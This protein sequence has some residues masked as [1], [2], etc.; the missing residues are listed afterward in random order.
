[1][2]KPQAGTVKISGPAI[3]PFSRSVLFIIFLQTIQAATNSSV[4]AIGATSFDSTTLI[5]SRRTRTRLPRNRTAAQSKME[6]APA[7]V[8]AEPQMTPPSAIAPCEIMMTMA[9]RRPRAQV[10]IVRCAATQSSQA[11]RVHPTPARAANVH[12]DAPRSLW[13][14]YVD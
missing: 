4:S 1:M 2:T 6:L 11:D 13:I 14:G 3:V 9:F 10:G 12:P 7:I 5:E 8:A